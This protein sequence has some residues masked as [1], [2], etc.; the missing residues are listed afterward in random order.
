MASVEISQRDGLAFADGFGVQAPRGGGRN[1]Q[2]ISF[3]R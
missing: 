1:E 3:V 2:E